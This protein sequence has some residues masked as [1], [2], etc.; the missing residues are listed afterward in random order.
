MREITII[1]PKRMEASLTGL[2]VEIDGKK[3]GKLGN[4]GRFSIQLADNAHEIY[5]H[6]GL[7]AGKHFSLRQPI[8][9]GGHSYTFQ[10]DMMS[11]TSGYAPVI[12]PSAGEQLKDTLRI[13][14]LMGAQLTEVLLNAKLREAVAKLP[15]ARF[16]LLLGE[17]E[18]SLTLCCGPERKT[19]YSSPYSQT[20]GGLIGATLNAINHA[21]LHTPEGREKMTRQIFAEY[22]VYL[23]GYT[24]TG[25]N[26]L[27]YTG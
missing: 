11:V 14:T 20:Q 13:I 19:V 17:S 18:W 25:E 21:D 7:M 26:E 10:I 2:V 12:R 4:G 8:P 1:R 22:L 9:S 16:V 5:L 3:Q 27:T 15:E 24:Q 6:G 23:P